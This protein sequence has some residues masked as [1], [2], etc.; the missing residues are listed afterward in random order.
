MVSQSI[1][2]SITVLA[3]KTHLLFS[4][5]WDGRRGRW[6]CWRG[7]TRRHYWRRHRCRKHCLRRHCL[8]NAR[9]YIGEFNLVDYR[10]IYNTYF[11]CSYSSCSSP[12][13][14]ST[15]SVRPSAQRLSWRRRLWRTSTRASTTPY[16]LRL[17][18]LW[19]QR[20]M[21]KWHR[22]VKNSRLLCAVTL[23]RLRAGQ[24]Q[25]FYRCLFSIY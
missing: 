24:N 25:P 22:Q 15:A 11:S 19:R 18:Q 1:N 4:A 20:P 8:E 13:I 23:T 2:P 5:C 6:H 7:S 16:Y 17:K 10:L 14:S 21:S 9:E 3:C 12:P